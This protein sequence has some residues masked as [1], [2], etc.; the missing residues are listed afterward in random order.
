[1]EAIVQ[2]GE[3]SEAEIRET[4]LQLIEAMETT[5]MPPEY[6]YA[7]K[8]TGRFVVEDNA[9]TFTSSQIDEWNEAIEEFHRLLAHSAHA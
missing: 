3:F 1:V 9:R 5:G 2:T 7:A 8:K 4:F 6:V